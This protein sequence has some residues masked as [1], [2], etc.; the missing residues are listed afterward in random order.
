MKP[1]DSCI[2]YDNSHGG[3]DWCKKHEYGLH[4]TIEAALLPTPVVTNYDRLISKTPE[5]MADILFEKISQA[6]MP[7]IVVTL[8]GEGAAYA[9]KNGEKGWI[10]ARNVVVN[11]TTGAGDASIGSFL[12][13]LCRLGV[14]KDNIGT[15]DGALLGEA[16]RFAAEYCSMSVQ[17]EGAIPSYPTLEEMKNR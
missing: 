1:C 17:H 11:D 4:L 8:G 16:V 12:W 14:S 3:C 9:M 2:D 10:P 6:D 15:V 7:G 13:K 5:E